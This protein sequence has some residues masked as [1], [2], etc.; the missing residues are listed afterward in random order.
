MEMMALGMTPDAAVDGIA[1]DQEARDAISRLGEYDLQKIDRA[2]LSSLGRE[3]KK[4]GFI[5]AGVMIAAPDEYEDLPE[6]FYASRIR[7]LAEAS[8]I[9]TKGDALS[10]KTFEIRLAAAAG[11]A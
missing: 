10:L 8:S 4:A 9:E 7:A 1:L 2:I 6:M 3:W 11:V 5:T